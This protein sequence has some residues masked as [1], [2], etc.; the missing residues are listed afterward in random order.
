MLSPISGMVVL[1]CVFNVLLVFLLLVDITLDCDW[2]AIPVDF[3]SFV[4]AFSNSTM[5]FILTGGAPDFKPGAT[6]MHYA[7]VLSWL[8]PIFAAL[9]VFLTGGRLF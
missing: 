1:L 3:G 2:G 8:A 6:F 9:L 4:L 5:D 7:N